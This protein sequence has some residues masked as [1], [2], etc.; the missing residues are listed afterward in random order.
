MPVNQS[1]VLSVMERFPGD[2][3][4]VLSLFMERETFR[5]IC[6]DYE[7]CLSSL[8]YWRSSPAVAAAARREEYALLLGDLEA[9]ISQSLEESRRASPGERR[10][11]G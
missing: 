3:D 2:R 6:E 4:R 9:E 5:T 11:E 8:L 10:E 7:K 1:S